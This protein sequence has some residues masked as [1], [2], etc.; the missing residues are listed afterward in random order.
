MPS[1]GQAELVGVVLLIGL[2]IIGTTAIVALGA[3]TIADSRASAEVQS[4]EHAMTLFDSTVTNVALGDAPVRTVRFGRTDGRF[5]LREDVGT[6]RIEHHTEGGAPPVE[7]NGCES[8]A[9]VC[10]I[11]LG[12]MVYTHGGTELASQGG[13]VWKRQGG[14]TTM[15][16]PPEFHY[17]DGTLTLPA[18]TTTGTG[19]AS[20]APAATIRPAGG[21]EVAHSGAIEN[22]TVTVTV[23][24][25]Y[26]EGWRQH[27]EERTTGVV[28]VDHDDHS[29]TVELVSTESQGR[30]GLASSDNAIS[31]RGLAGE[32]P[33]ER[34]ELTLHPYEDDSSGFNG[35]DWRLRDEGSALEL[36]FENRDNAD[37]IDLTVT[38]PDGRESHTFEDAFAVDGQRVE[39]DLTAD[40]EAEGESLDS[41]LNRHL[42]AAGPDV[43]FAVHDRGRGTDDRIS[44]ERSWGS[45]EYESSGQ[46]IAYL[47]VT[48]NAVAVRFN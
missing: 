24:S 32:E 20:G 48:E 30:F 14:A 42:A 26:Y 8:A 45:L 41:L 5:E 43:T 7:W 6:M 34:F 37:A 9:G 16:S 2:T 36:A 38:S 47:H 17:R 46:S 44:Y 31:L 19:S 3:G 29:V 12:A 11:D 25:P 21:S 27:F 15:G 35:L 40:R 10:E 13:G 28:S 22:G 33:I 18:V 23:R 39:A 1:R 4:T